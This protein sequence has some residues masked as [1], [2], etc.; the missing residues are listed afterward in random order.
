MTRLLHDAGGLV[1]AE[2]DTVLVKPYTE[3]QLTHA[4]SS[5]VQAVGDLGSYT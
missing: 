3:A 5:G 2:V 4:N 1:K